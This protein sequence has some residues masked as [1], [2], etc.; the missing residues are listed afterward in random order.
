MA[1]LLATLGMLLTTLCWSCPRLGLQAGAARP[2]AT[3]EVWVANSGSAGLPE[4]V[5]PASGESE[6]KV[7]PCPSNASGPCLLSPPLK[8]TGFGAAT[9]RELPASVSA[10]QERPAPVELEVSRIWHLLARGTL[11]ERSPTAQL[12]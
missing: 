7:E 10:P 12:R 5:P 1:P 3:P 6:R 8:L 2:E 4:P 9:D 11:C